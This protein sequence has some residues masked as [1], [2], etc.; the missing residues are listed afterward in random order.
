MLSHKCYMRGRLNEVCCCS[1]VTVN[2]EDPDSG[3]NGRVTYAITS[4]NDGTPFRI[5][6][7]SGRIRTNRVLNR[8]DV[9]HYL[10]HVEA[11]D[12]VRTLTR[13]QMLP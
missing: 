8:E 6:A 11:T 2:A 5:E 4:G 9:D 10:L 12:H 1:V 13:S 3:D 7:G